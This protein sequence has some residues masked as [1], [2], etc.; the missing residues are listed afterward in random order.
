MKKELA[1]INAEKIPIPPR[2]GVIVTCIFLLLSG[3]SKRRFL[4]AIYMTLGI[5]IRLNSRLDINISGYS[6]Y[7]GKKVISAIAVKLMIKC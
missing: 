2:L 6:M 4:L 3:T 1:I 5:D 7:G